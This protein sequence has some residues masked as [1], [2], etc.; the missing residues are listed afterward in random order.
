MGCGGSKAA[1]VQPAVDVEPVLGKAGNLS[2]GGS[3]KAEAKTSSFQKD[4]Q[5]E[6]GEGEDVSVTP[7]SIES[8]VPEVNSDVASYREEG[9]GAA[10]LNH[11]EENDNVVMKVENVNNAAKQTLGETR[12]IDS[13]KD[14]IVA[15]A[16]DVQVELGEYR[17]DCNICGME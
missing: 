5:G 17:G 4:E 14:M 6:G 11:V 16:S 2:V 15:R 1:G 3:A 12:I 10:D 13:S 9:E 7:S 8:P